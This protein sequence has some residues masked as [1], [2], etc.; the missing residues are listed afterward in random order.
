MSRYLL[1]P[2][3]LFFLQPVQANETCLF[4]SQYEPD[5]M[6]EVSTKD[7]LQTS[8][9]MNYKGSPIFRFSTG[10]RN[11]Y[12]GQYFSISNISDSLP[13]QDKNLVYGSVITIIGD[14]S[15]MGT[16]KSKRK[17]GLTKVFFPNFGLNYY[18]SLAS[19]GNTEEGRFEG[20][21]KKINSILSAAEGFW[22]PS[23]VC[24]KYVPYGW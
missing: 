6:I 16:P 23:E 8:G 20:R 10:I 9:Y 3:I 22:I 14:Q 7:L 21:T 18:Y 19:D 11:G 12:G 2:L 13:S 17:Q 4:V 15:A 1:T 5:L 24:K